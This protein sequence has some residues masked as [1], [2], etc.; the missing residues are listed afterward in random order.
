MRQTACL[1]VNPIAVN[2]FAALFNCTPAGRASDLM[3]APAKTFSKVGWGLMT[4][5]LVDPPGFSC[6]M[7]FAPAFSVGLAVDYP[8]CFISVMNLSLNVCSFNSMMSL[9]L[10]SHEQCF[11]GN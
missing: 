5:L 8:S 9:K 10:H 7:C 2:R 4:Y 11:F 6:W 3:M 1:V